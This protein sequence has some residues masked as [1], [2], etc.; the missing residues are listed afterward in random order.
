M[1]PYIKVKRSKSEYFKRII[2]LARDILKI[3]KKIAK[4]IDFLQ[5]C[6]IFCIENWI[7]R[8]YGQ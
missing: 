1:F 7:V 3:S 6:D 8:L 4:Y 2:E 5:E